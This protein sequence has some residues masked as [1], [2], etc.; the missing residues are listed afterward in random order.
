MICRSVNALLVI[1]GAAVA[2]QAQ[3]QVRIST[4]VSNISQGRPV[5]TV[6]G[7]GHPTYYPNRVLVHFKNGAP[8]NFLP[9]SG[10]ARA[11]P[12]DANLFLVQKPPGLTV[13]DAVA[14]YKAN[15]NVN[16]AEPDYHVQ[17]VATP[18]DP[19]WANQWDMTKI[20][21]PTVWDSPPNMIDTVAVIIDTGIDYTHE[22]LQGNLWTNPADSTS[23]GYTCIN[24]SCVSGGA[25]DFGHGTHV[26]GTIGAV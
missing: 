3:N 22:D 18:N 4:S 8:K 16:Y 12:R 21:A 24:G 1:A 14:R 11:F 6:S 23:H 17:T 7:A 13:P 10:P 2:L 19:L 26:A 9:G 5:T 15:A 25:D 20:S